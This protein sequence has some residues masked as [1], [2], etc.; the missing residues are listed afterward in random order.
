MPPPQK[1]KKE[2]ERSENQKFRQSAGRIWAKENSLKTKRTNLG[3]FT[4]KERK[5]YCSL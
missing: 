5:I 2:E 1:K 4:G 3:K